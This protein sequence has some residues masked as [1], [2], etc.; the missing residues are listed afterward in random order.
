MKKSNSK[1]I[2]IIFGLLYRCH[3]LCMTFGIPAIESK[4]HPYSLTTS[5]MED[6]SEHT[7]S[8]HDCPPEFSKPQK[9]NDDPGVY[10]ENKNA[11]F[12]FAFVRGASSSIDHILEAIY[13]RLVKI[14]RQE[15]SRI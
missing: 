14:H 9:T 15:T 12:A 7:A 1:Q 10:K 6:G 2:Y 13:H 5:P 4:G 3:V 11:S 8:F